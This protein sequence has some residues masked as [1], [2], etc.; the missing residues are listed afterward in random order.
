MTI[1]HVP[2]RLPPQS[3]DAEKAV[4]AAMLL[5]RDAIG[6]AVE[7]LQPEPFYR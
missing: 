1:E 2:G 7:M 5:S 3:L 6:V 4:L